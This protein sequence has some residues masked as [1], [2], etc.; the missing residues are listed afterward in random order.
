MTISQFK[1]TLVLCFIFLISSCGKK[2]GLC[3]LP[4]ANTALKSALQYKM[5]KWK[6][7]ATYAGIEDFETE[8]N[9]IIE[10]LTITENSFYRGDDESCDCRA[11][12]QFEDHQGFIKAVTGPVTKVKSEEHP[13]N[14]VYMR[15]EEKIQYLDN[16][17]FEFFYILNRKENG[18]L[19][20]L[21][22]YPL[23]LQPQVDNAGK[24][25]WDYMEYI[26]T[27]K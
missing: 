25:I 23:P 15:M 19:E 26:L 22:S 9:K 1:T 14:S 10:K 21:Q 20:A 17:G 18:K 24:M 11:R 2:S 5:T 4:G 3:E 16:D 8:V 6:T 27:Q 13:L 7:N 12:I